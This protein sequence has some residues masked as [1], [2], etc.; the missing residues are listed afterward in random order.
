MRDFTL[1][2]SQA[3]LFAQKIKA[4]SISV[5]KLSAA[6]PHLAKPQESCFLPI[7]FMPVQSYPSLEAKHIG[8]KYEE[9]SLQHKLL[10]EE[11]LYS[12]LWLPQTWIK[13]RCSIS[14]LPQFTGGQ[15]PHVC[16]D[17]EPLVVDESSG[18]GPTVTTEQV[19][20]LLMKLNVCKFMRL[21][22][23]HPRVL[24]EMADV[25][26]KLLSIIFERSWLLGEIQLEGTI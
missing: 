17:P 10:Y 5:D 24:R 8:N 12:F 21:G 20:D 11:D 3:L 19:R 1:L 25:V 2:F 6:V 16:Q 15:A 23:M 9:K 7:C 14:A 4:F 18:F 22:D 26:A 13:L